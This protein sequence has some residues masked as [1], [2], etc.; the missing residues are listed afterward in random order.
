[1]L[2]V[3]GFLFYCALSKSLPLANRVVSSTKPIMHLFG[4]FG[5][6]MRIRGAL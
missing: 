1:M 3:E 4:L 2:G 5:L 6:V